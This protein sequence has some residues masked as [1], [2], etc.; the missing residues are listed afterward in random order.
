MAGVEWKYSYHW[1]EVTG[2][3]ANNR[4][5]LG[6]YQFSILVLAESVDGVISSYSYIRPE[7]FVYRMIKYFI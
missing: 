1:F 2:T 5:K 7:R 3:S 4:Y 6:T